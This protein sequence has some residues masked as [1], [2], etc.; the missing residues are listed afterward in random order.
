MLII[1]RNP[2]AI[3]AEWVARQKCFYV[4]TKRSWSRP[5]SPKLHFVSVFK[6]FSKNLQMSTK[7]SP[8]IPKII[9]KKKFV[10]LF[11]C[12]YV[13]SQN[14]VRSIKWKRLELQTWKWCQIVDNLEEPCPL[15]LKIFRKNAPFPPK[16]G[17]QIFLQE[18]NF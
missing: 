14:L 17:F 9:I 11:V 15:F 2:C 5:Y 6:I 8:Q 4:P 3:F 10:C 13:W 12:L 16:I 7:P 1:L 18:Q